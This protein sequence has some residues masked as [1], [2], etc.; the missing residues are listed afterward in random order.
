MLASWPE[1]EG[2]KIVRKIGKLVA[3]YTVPHFRI[4][5]IQSVVSDVGGPRIQY[6]ILIPKLQNLKNSFKIIIISHNL[7]LI[8]PKPP[9]LCVL[10]TS[11]YEAPLSLSLSL[12]SLA[13]N[14]IGAHISR[15]AA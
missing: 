6:A 2:S 13:H 7:N 1:N 15:I 9:V 10:F 11:L 4:F 5:I 12:P 3:E 14:E 8:F